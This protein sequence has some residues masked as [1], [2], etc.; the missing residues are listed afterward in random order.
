[1]VICRDA[2]NWFPNLF[3]KAA[4]LSS[5]NR[6]KQRMTQMVIIMALQAHHSAVNC[7]KR[8]GPVPISGNCGSPDGCN[9]SPAGAQASNRGDVKE[10]QTLRMGDFNTLHANK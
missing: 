3:R 5:T 2:D 6:F 10:G 1:M 7:V 9:S 8:K 4:E